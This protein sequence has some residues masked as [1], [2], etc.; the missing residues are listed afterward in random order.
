MASS[1]LNRWPQPGV[2]TPRVQVRTKADTSS[3]GWGAPGSIWKKIR[4][5]AGLLWRPH[6]LF[7][8][9]LPSRPLLT[10]CP[11]SFPTL[12]SCPPGSSRPSPQ[13]PAAQVA[14]IPNAHSPADGAGKR[15][16]R[17]S[18]PGDAVFPLKLAPPHIPRKRAERGGSRYRGSCP[19]SLPCS[20]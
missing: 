2:P 16:H 12:I 11:Q 19:K 14:P 17:F 15:D 18:P 3:W 4:P 1:S 5:P 20:V 10:S 13:L 9:S 7:S 8:S 6:F